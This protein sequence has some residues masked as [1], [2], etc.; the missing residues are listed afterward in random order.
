[1][2][3]MMMMLML[4]FAKYANNLQ[5]SKFYSLDHEPPSDIQS[6]IIAVASLLIH[7]LALTTGPL[8]NYYTALLVSSHRFFFWAS[9]CMSSPSIILTLVS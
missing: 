1:M 5:F 8:I 6:I 9:P 7:P 3:M 4:S 2:M